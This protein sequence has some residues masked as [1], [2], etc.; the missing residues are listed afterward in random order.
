MLC[1][2]CKA[3]QPLLEILPGLALSLLE[4]EATATPDH[5]QPAR[6]IYLRQALR[7]LSVTGNLLYIVLKHVPEEHVGFMLQT[8]AATN[9]T[10]RKLSLQVVADTHFPYLPL[11]YLPPSLEYL[12]MNVTVN[13][14]P[15]VEASV[16]IIEGSCQGVSLQKLD[17]RL[18]DDDGFVQVN[19]QGGQLSIQQLRCKDHFV[20]LTPGTGPG[21]NITIGHLD[22]KGLSFHS[23]LSNVVVQHLRLSM[24]LHG[25]PEV[26][27]HLGSLSSLCV[28][29]SSDADW[30]TL[31]PQ[32]YDLRACKTLVKLEAPKPGGLDLWQVPTDCHC[33]I[34]DTV[35]DV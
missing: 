33:V 16:A 13:P 4:A 12:S 32:A 14:W 23:S 25:N 24:W 31:A 34:R 21:R 19:S 27:Q 10:L 7:I 22:C 28:E 15:G 3:V 1:M 8:L 29:L 9:P 5:T 20:S 30:Q 11:A 2:I 26:L 6:P 18:S 17:I 35:S